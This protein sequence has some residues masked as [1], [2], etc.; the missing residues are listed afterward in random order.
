MQQDINAIKCKLAK[1]ARQKDKRDVGFGPEDPP[2]WWPMSII[3]PRSGKPFTPAG[4]WDF[5]A[6]QLDKNETSIKQVLLKKPCGKL[7]YE[8]R[9]RTEYEIIYIKVRLAKGKIIGRSF[10]T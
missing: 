10:H 7:A 4:V 5:I 8:F 2:R 9:V 6:E 1:L 3:D